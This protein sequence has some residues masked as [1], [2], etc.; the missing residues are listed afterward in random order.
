MAIDIQG[1]INR[2]VQSI[3]KDRTTEIQSNTENKV[4]QTQN[5]ANSSVITANNLKLLQLLPG[6]VLSGNITDIRGSLIE[7][8][9]NNNQSVT[10]RLTENFEYVIGQRAIFTVKSNDGKQLVLVPRDRT[11]MAEANHL[12]LA[13][14][15]KEAGV[16]VTDKNIEL[17]KSMMK[18]QISVDGQTVA[19]YA[20]SVAQF[21]EASPESIVMLKKYDIPLTDE[22][23]AQYENYKNNEYQILNQTSVMPEELSTLLCEMTI[24]DEDEAVDLF[25]EIVDTFEWNVSDENSM[26]NPLTDTQK[27]Q[28]LEILG[29][30]TN[31]V[32]ESEEST[33]EEILKH[34]Q[35]A[36]KTLP[37]QQL[38]DLFQN[39]SFRTLVNS[40]MDSKMLF[41]PRMLVADG[42]PV[43]TFYQKLM[44]KTEKIQKVLEDYGK[45]DSNFAK[46]TS[47]LNGNM[48]FMN[49]MN[50]MLTYVQLPL[51]FAEEN[52]HG[53]LYVYTKKNL[54]RKKGEELSAMLHLEMES[55]GQVDVMIRMLNEKVTT[56]FTLESEEM[57]LFVE[58]HIDEL[59]A[60]L[61]KKGYQMTSTVQMKKEP[62]KEMK[63]G[64]KR[65]EKQERKIDFFEDIVNRE[66][67]TGTLTRFSFD[68]RT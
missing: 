41:D 8:M 18:E 49:A 57:L 12:V 32:I 22:M 42:Q 25:G 48:K 39:D 55:L 40:A 68:V 1:I 34:L 52:A 17:L 46:T 56:D 35:T 20:K 24:T 28:L 60:R 6:Q 38:G 63:K 54:L 65:L 27:R 5:T 2:T 59:N 44:S 31:E 36:T 51:K 50:E 53:D 66:R 7:I 3:T 30:D 67:K 21:P 13:G 19:Q 26:T 61:A 11:S 43:Q 10:A 4:I 9:L 58:E 47:N 64:K 33:P 23:V 45:E 37:K 29:E 15:L 14:I 62:E 16:E